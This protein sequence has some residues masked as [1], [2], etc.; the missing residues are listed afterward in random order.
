MNGIR[1]VKPQVSQLKALW[2]IEQAQ[3][4]KRIASRFTCIMAAIL[5]MVV[6]ILGG[7]GLVLL[8]LTIII[9]LIFIPVFLI[10]LTQ[11]RIRTITF[12]SPRWI[13]NRSIPLFITTIAALTVITGGALWGHSA[14]IEKTTTSPEK[15]I[16]WREDLTV[17]VYWDERIFEEIRRG[18]A[19]AAG[20]LGFQYENV[21]TQEEANLHVWPYSWAMKCKWP[22]TKAFVSL[23]PSPDAQGSQWGEIYI[24]GFKNPILKGKLND[25]SMMAHETAHILAAQPHFG[26]GLMAEAGGNGA[27]WFTEKEIESMCRKISSYRKSLNQAPQN[28]K[29]NHSK[30]GKVPETTGCGAIIPQRT[31]ITQ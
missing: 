22:S 16:P 2:N 23:D 5:L 6:G 28:E 30:S 29:N 24:C 31:R 14:H 12:R 27:D 8:S 17:K 19:D 15:G 21:A 7:A 25:Y 11:R 10:S 4:H 13:W 9:I 18:L 1:I 3:R 20:V 26:D